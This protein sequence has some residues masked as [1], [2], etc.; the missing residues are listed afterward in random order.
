MRSVS[1]VIEVYLHLDLYFAALALTP[2]RALI[3][4]GAS[5][6]VKC[7]FLIE[8]ALNSVFILHFFRCRYRAIAS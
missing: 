7:L 1:V 6:A 3:A 4:T 8:P 2:A 5:M